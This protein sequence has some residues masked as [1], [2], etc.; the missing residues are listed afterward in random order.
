MRGK[1]TNK[2][3][4]CDSSDR[5]QECMKYR[6]KKPLNVFMINDKYILAIYE[7]E[8]SEYDII[9]RYRQKEKDGKWSRIRTP[10]HIHWTV[11]VLIKKQK[12]SELT[13]SFIN[14]LLKRWEEIEPI[15]E[16]SE[17][18][19]RTSYEYIA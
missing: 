18:I 17:R 1:Q 5:L 7:G 3:H 13:K 9:I 16:E 8:L 2:T 11:D 10:K 6:G 12:D 19:K 4:P 14:Y 15:R